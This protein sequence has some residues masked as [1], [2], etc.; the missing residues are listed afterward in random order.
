MANKDELP[1]AGE[2]LLY[3][4]SGLNAPM[5]V[6][7]EGETVR[8]SQKQLA[9]LYGVAVSTINEHVSHIYDDE[10][11]HP[12]ATIRKFRIVQTEGSRQVGAE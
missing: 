10:E 9:E 7:L 4:G 6:R 8:L 12:E 3:Q 5:Q 11:L 1:P 2:L